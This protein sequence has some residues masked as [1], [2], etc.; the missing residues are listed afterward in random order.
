MHAMRKANVSPSGGPGPSA[1]PTG[2][3]VF[4]LYAISWSKGKIVLFVLVF[5][6]ECAENT[7]TD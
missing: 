3:L 7:D 2:I 5:V 4:S 6:F 1:V